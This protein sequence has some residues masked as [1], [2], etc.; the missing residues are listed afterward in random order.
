LNPHNG[1]SADCFRAVSSRYHNKDIVRVC[2][3]G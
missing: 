1:D 2:L 3:S